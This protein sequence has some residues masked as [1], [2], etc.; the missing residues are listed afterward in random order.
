MLGSL[1]QYLTPFP[2]QTQK[3]MFARIKKLQRQFMAGPMCIFSFVAVK[4][5]NILSI[6]LANHDLVVTMLQ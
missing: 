1:P 2:I 3:C 4:K 5:T 6:E